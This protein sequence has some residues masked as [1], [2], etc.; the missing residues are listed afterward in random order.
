MKFVCM[1]SKD[2]PGSATREESETLPP[3]FVVAIAVPLAPSN[4][5]KPTGVLFATPPIRVA[6]YA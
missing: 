4:P 3:P 5:M 1:V 2:D 6:A